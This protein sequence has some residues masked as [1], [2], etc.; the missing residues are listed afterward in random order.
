MQKKEVIIINLKLLQNWTLKMTFPEGNKFVKII[1]QL[2]NI[3]LFEKALKLHRGKHNKCEI[4]C[5]SCI[6]EILT[7]V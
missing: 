6:D 2:Y 3:D 7:A 1:I 4:D 5:W